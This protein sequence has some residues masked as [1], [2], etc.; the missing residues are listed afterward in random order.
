M[1]SSPVTV[2]KTFEGGAAS[3][4]KQDNRETLNVLQVNVLTQAYRLMRGGC[5]AAR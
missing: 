3:G 2:T 4:S 1:G 5:S